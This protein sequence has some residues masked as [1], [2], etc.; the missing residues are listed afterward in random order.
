MF[1]ARDM[2]FTG[3]LQGDLKD[4]INVVTI[5]LIVVSNVSKA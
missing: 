4:V 3:V 5:S 1:P 2:K